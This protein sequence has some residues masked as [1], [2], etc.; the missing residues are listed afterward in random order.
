[1]ITSEPVSTDEPE[2]SSEEICLMYLYLPRNSIFTQEVHFVYRS[3]RIS[4]DTA[5]RRCRY[6]WRLPK[7]R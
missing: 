7:G 1:V 3:R 4:V 5:H 6:F 2:F